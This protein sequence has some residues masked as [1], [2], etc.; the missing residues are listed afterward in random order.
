MKAYGGRI[1][2]AASREQSHLRSA[3]HAPRGPLNFY[4]VLSSSSETPRFK[5]D[6][7]LGLPYLKPQ[8]GA[9]ALAGGTGPNCFPKQGF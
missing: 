7:F 1:Y 6:N 9:I 8:G 5:L 2:K 3:S 4:Y